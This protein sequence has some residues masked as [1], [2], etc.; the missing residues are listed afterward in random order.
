MH[1]IEFI[2][3]PNQPNDLELNQDWKY[4]PLTTKGRGQ[5]KY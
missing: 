1:S 2:I 5:T 3:D 4:F